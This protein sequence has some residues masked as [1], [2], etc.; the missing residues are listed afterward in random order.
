MVRRAVPR[1]LRLPKRREVRRQR[2]SGA[3]DNAAARHLYSSLGFVRYGVERRSLIVDG[4]WLDEVLLVLYLQ[5]LDAA[6][7]MTLPGP[8]D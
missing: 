1:R 3:R 6:G 8:A 4:R 7:Y 2:L 5:P